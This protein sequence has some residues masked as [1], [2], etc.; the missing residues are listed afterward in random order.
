MLILPIK[1]LRKAKYRGYTNINFL[2][3]SNILTSKQK[4]FVLSMDMELKELLHEN[5]FKDH[6][7]CYYNSNT[8]FIQHPPETIESEIHNSLLAKTVNQIGIGAGDVK[9]K[10]VPKVPFEHLTS[11]LEFALTSP[12]IGEINPLNLYPIL[13]LKDEKDPQF[14]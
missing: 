1:V 12:T 13:N 10:K 5:P 8:G 11:N 6:G 9:N 2:P 3:S 7:Y 4:R 14:N